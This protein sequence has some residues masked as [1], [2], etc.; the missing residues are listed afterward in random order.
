MKKS[1]WIPLS[2]MICFFFP[3]FAFSQP[4]PTPRAL[5][6]GTSS[7]G[8]A[9]YIIS[10]GMGEIISKKTGISIAVEAV[11][12]SDAN[13]RALSRKKVDLAMLNSM[14]V[15]AAYLGEGPFAKEGKTDLRI[16][17]Q[18]QQ[19]LR[20]IVVRTASGIKTPA[21][22]RGS[23]FIGKRPALAELE[24][25]TDALLKAYG[26]PK[27]SLKIL[28][29]TETKEVLEALK[30]GTVDGAV[31]P[32]GLRSSTLLELA[33]FVDVTFLSIPEDKMELILQDLGP[34]FHEA[35]IPKGTYR[36]QMEDVK[37]PSLL[38]DIAVRADFPED[39]AYL[40][41]KTLLESQKELTMV[42]S[43]GKEWTISNT[44]KTPPA[45]FHSG[46]IKYFKEKGLWTP[47][48][49]KSQEKLLRKGKN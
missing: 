19:S 20:N 27:D 38:T 35:V 11:G 10:V 30:L 12:G 22:L 25:I 6:F 17:A 36:G 24:M 41:T 29:T 34:A 44:L 13:A 33:Q 32:A 21:D 37:T 18:G 7:V 46:A 15:A 8:S 26:I 16:I 14:S 43:E 48:L 31:I 39:L 49:E 1:L 9:F 47:D 5:S 4:T 3:L 42:H 2:I 28:Q 23:R 45:P 40:I